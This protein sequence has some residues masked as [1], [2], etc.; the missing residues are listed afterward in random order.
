MKED[1][2]NLSEKIKW[3]MIL[4][5]VVV[6]FMLGF[7]VLL[8]LKE[9]TAFFSTPLR[10]LYFFIG[11]FYFLTIAYSIA[12]HRGVDNRRFALVQLGVDLFLISGIVSVTGGVEGLFSIVYFLA[13]IGASILL[14]RR[15]SLV[16]AAIS[17]LFYSIAVWAPY[18]P[19]LASFLDYD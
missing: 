16:T 3:L 10:S 12:Y 17:A 5:V 18:F 1:S 14:Y 7:T 9:G 11:V 8:Q 4:R 6:T 13:I 15:G 19:S 2:G